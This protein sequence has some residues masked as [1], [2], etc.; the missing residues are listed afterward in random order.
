MTVPQLVIDRIGGFPSLHRWLDRGSCSTSPHAGY[1]ILRGG[2]F[3]GHA[4]LMDNPSS[5]SGITYV[6]IEQRRNANYKNRCVSDWPMTNK[7]VEYHF[8]GYTVY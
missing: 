6:S 2:P 3:D 1:A 7:N 5:S 4:V 8:D